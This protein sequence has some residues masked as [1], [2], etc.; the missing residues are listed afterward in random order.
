MDGHEIVV[1]FPA[2]AGY[3]SLHHIVQTGFGAHPA[4][5]KMDTGDNFSGGKADHSPPTHLH[6][7]LLN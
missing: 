5:Y 3:Y 2:R 6:G 7:L 1:R 4:S